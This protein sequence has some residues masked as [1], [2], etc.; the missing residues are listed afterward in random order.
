MSVCNRF[1][2]YSTIAHNKIAKLIP[3]QVRFGNSSSEI[4]DYLGCRKWGCNKWG[5]KGCLAALPG[6]RPKSAKI[7]LFLPF[8]PFSGGC[9]EHLGN[10]RTSEEKGLFPQIS[11]DFLK[12]PSLK[13]P[14]AALQNILAGISAPKK[15]FSPP[16]PHSR[17][18]PSRPLAPPT[19]SPG[20][21]PPPLSWHFSIKNRHPPP[22]PGT[23]PPLSPPPS[24]KNKKYP[25][26][27]PRYDSQNISVR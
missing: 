4:T 10:P 14:F 21:T 19:P 1:G 26:R 6:N 2:Y 20:R 9:R 23:S 16:P 3:K 25:K 8:S 22:S 7:A 17:Q 5:L 12:P 13:P 27:P 11:S 24:R 15:I 18:T